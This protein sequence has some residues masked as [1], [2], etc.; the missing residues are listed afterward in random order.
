MFFLKFEKLIK[1]IFEKHIFQVYNYYIIIVDIFF[2]WGLVMNIGKL[3]KRFWAYCFDLIMVCGI[4][5]GILFLIR[6]L[7]NYNIISEVVK[8]VH[9]IL[10]SEIS[11]GQAYYSLTFYLSYGLLFLIYEISFLSSKLSATIG[12][13]TLGLEVVCYNGFDFQ[14]ILIR[15][16]LKVTTMLIPP[17]TLSL[18]IF[19]AFSKTKQSLYDKW[20][21][22]CVITKDNSKIYGSNPQMTLEEFFE[23]MKSRGLRL[24]SEQQALSEEIYGSPIPLGQ[25]YNK[26][27]SSHS[28][29]GVLVVFILIAI[30][31][32]FALYVFPDIQKL[33]ALF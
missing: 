1:N 8:E 21:N 31:V 18:F 22:T 3:F 17:L 5:W 13:L 32:S 33:Y 26:P 30:S 7:S 10:S 24:Y 6:I 9:K 12:K 28:M 16:L 29:F 20:S 2:K 14:K 23:E 4:Y 19:S 11:I 25:T 27:A 15:S